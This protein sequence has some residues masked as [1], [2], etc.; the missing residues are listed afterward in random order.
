MWLVSVRLLS[1]SGQ[2]A[3]L[4]RRPQGAGVSAITTE[5]GRLSG[6]LAY[7]LVAALVFGETALFFGFAPLV[8][9][10]LV[11]W[12]VRRRRPEPAPAGRLRQTDIGCGDESSPRCRFPPRAPSP[13]PADAT[14][15][16]LTWVAGGAGIARVR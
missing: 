5:L 14:A 8:V 7:A 3:D 4:I 2:L 16:V 9:A 1:K 11:V 10:A 6:P 15:L 13:A 12:A